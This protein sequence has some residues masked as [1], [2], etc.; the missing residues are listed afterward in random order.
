MHKSVHTSLVPDSYTLLL[1]E[2]FMFSDIC[3]CT[4]SFLKAQQIPRLILISVSF[5]FFLARASSRVRFIKLEDLGK[6]L[7]ERQ[8]FTKIIF[9]GCQ[10]Y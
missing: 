8:H 5:S 10:M 2:I 3:V 6:G 9:W 7:R 1:F 4:K